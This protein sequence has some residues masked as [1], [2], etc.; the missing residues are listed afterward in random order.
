METAAINYHIILKNINPT[1]F[2]TINKIQ[3]IRKY[4]NI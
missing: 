4:W 3:N 2:Q 1:A